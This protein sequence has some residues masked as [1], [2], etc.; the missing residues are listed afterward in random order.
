MILLHYSSWTSSRKAK[1]WLEE[2]GI[3]VTVRVL[4][5]NLPTSEDV[6]QWMKQTNTPL[7]VFFNTNGKM[8][9]ELNLKDKWDYMTEDELLK[10]LTSDYK[11]F[12]R[13][14]LIGDNFVLSGFKV[15]EWEMLKKW[16]KKSLLNFR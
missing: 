11:L 12:K 2:N 13:P 7:K 1:A 8:Y 14:T 16:Y 15:A 10:L 4:N 5:K 6:R 3:D 9:K